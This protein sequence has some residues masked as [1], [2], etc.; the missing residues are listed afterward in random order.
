[1]SRR[2]VGLMASAIFTP[3]VLPGHSR[4]FHREEGRRAAAA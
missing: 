1:M 4:M 3:I 2:V